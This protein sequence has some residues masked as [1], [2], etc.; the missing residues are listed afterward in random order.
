MVKLEPQ[1]DG[2]LKIA[3][4]GHDIER[5]IS[6]RKIKLENYTNYEEFKKLHALNS[7]EVLT[8]LITLLLYSQ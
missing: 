8:K 6:K 1:A 2:A 3:A 4:L 7:A 5:A